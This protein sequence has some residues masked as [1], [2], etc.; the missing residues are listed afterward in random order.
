VS[1]CIAQQKMIY[2]IA[3]RVSHKGRVRGLI[4]RI[5][6]ARPNQENEIH[7]IGQIDSQS[8]RSAPL[9][10]CI[11]VSPYFWKDWSRVI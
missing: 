10:S 9:N 11:T 1:V 4:Q 6:F 2:R 7:E 3:K 8:F 5:P